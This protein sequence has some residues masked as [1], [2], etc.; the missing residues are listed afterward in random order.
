MLLLYW[1]WSQYEKRCT[2]G[3][4]YRASGTLGTRKGEKRIEMT[5]YLGEIWTYWK[6]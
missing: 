3:N 2:S 5:D 4:N 6:K 1:A